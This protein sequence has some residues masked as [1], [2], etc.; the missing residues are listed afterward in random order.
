MVEENKTKL[1]PWLRLVLIGSLALNLLVVGV[2]VGAM[3]RFGRPGLDRPPHSIGTLMFRELSRED[4]RALWR[5]AQ[6]DRGDLGRRRA[7]EGVAVMAALR[8]VPFDPVSLEQVL[9]AQIRHREAFQQGVQDA[10]LARVSAMTEAE[11]AAY[12]D[13]LEHGLKRHSGK[14]GKWSDRR[15]RKD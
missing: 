11:R 6:E 5:R 13:R 12:A 4:R 15:S 8:Q 9:S 7:A 1:R 10:W 3:F 2:A 14:F